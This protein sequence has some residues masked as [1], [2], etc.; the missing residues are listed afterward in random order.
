MW[1]GS[2]K[3]RARKREFAQNNNPIDPGRFRTMRDTKVKDA[4]KRPAQGTNRDGAPPARPVLS[5]GNV[6]GVVYADA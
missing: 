1:Q 5:F 4:E 2:E 6:S 3:N